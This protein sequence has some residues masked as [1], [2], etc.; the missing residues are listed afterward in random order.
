[1]RLCVCVCECT[2]MYVCVLFLC[3]MC[4]LRFGIRLMIRFLAFNCFRLYEKSSILTEKIEFR[5]CVRM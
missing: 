2:C 3:M 5:L 1:M 4:G